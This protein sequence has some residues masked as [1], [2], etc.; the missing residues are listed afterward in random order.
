MK[1]ST[2]RSVATS[3]SRSSCRVTSEDTEISARFFNEARAVNLIGHRGWCRSSSLGIADRRRLHGDG[4]HPRHHPARAPEA[5]RA[6]RRDRSAADRAAA[7]S[8]LSAAH[9]KEI[10]HRDL[11]PGNV[12]LVQDPTMPLGQRVKLLDFGWPSSGRRVPPRISRAPRPGSIG[13]PTYMSPEQCRGL[14]SIDGRPTSMRWECC[15]TRCWS[16]GCRLRASPTARSWACT[17]T[18]AAAAAE[19]GAA[20]LGVGGRAGAPHAAEEAR[21]AP[22]GPR[23]RRGPDRDG[24]GGGALDSPSQHQAG[25]GLGPAGDERAPCAVLDA[26]PQCRAAL[27]MGSLRLR[28]AILRL[29]E[30]WPWL[31]EHT[32]PRQRLLLA[33]G[34]G[35]VLLTGLGLGLRGALRS[36][37]RRRWRSSPSR[38]STGRWPARRRGERHP[39]GGSD[40]DGA[41][42]WQSE[43]PS[44]SGEL[45]VVLR[46]PGTKIAL[47]SWTRRTMCSAA[48]RWSR[49]PRPRADT[50]R[51]GGAR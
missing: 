12:M 11:K 33:A 39:E 15:S 21:R 46:L 42:P 22:H 10:V 5:G 6:A 34:L 29:S 43:Q 7:G 20:C 26:G 28:H 36:G 3:P 1:R 19:R 30:R 47:C 16:G 51:R 44:K 9:T 23:S 25:G 13:T 2:T 27:R 45:E 50:A 4:V 38:R 48:R 31:A 35:F 14:K 17:C 8:A 41:D 49:S 40:R 37:L 24:G 18:R 32:S